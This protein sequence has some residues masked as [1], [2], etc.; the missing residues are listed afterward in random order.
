[1][2]TLIKLA[3]A[4]ALLF[5]ASAMSG[6][7]GSKHD[8]S[9]GGSSQYGATQ[10]T[11]AVCVFC[12]TPHGSDTSIKAPLWNKAL[13]TTG[14]TRYSDLGTATLDGSEAPVG[15]VSLACLSCHDGTQAMDVVINAP[16]S[17]GYNS[18]GASMDGGANMTANS[19][20]FIPNLGS[21]L[22]NDHPI[23]IQYAGGACMGTTADCVPASGGGDP[24][25][26]IAQYMNINGN[27]F[28][29][30]DESSGTSDQ[31]DKTD[32]ILYTRNDFAGGGG[33]VGPSVECAS[34]HDPHNDGSAD[35]TN[36]AF[37]RVRNTG[38]TICIACHS[39]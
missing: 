4:T 19:G 9:S 2:K 16:G 1:M 8:L 20:G 38:S 11:T 33:A 7:V 36:V 3:M 10:T 24:D 39:K 25:F 28:W 13:T 31:R 30:V 23:S 21:D 15:S 29:W 17:G 5:S 35:A 14:F 27:A 6:I 26:K 34:C 37:L 18:A 22:R 32:M 12:H